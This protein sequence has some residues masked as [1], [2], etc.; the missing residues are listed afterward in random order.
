MWA[1]YKTDRAVYKTDRAV[2][3]LYLLRKE[4]SGN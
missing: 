4:N 1:V 2:F 3:E